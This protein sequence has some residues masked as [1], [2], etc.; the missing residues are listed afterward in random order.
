MLKPENITPEEQA[1]IDW[2]KSHNWPKSAEECTESEIRE[3]GMLWMDATMG[4][5]ELSV[6]LYWLCEFAK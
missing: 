6:H 2:F 1:V 5:G 3:I 4:S